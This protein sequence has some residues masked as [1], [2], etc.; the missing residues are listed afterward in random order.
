MSAGFISLGGQAVVSRDT[1]VSTTNSFP[2]AADS[3]EG[4]EAFVANKLEIGNG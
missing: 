4:A 2:L 1:L 3:D